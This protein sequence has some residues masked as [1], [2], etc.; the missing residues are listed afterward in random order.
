MTTCKILSPNFLNFPYIYIYNW[1]F[2]IT[3]H[4][5]H[6]WKTL[7]YS[8]PLLYVR[9][10]GKQKSPWEHFKPFHFHQLYHWVF[11]FFLASLSWFDKQSAKPRIPQQPASIIMPKENIVFYSKTLKLLFLP[12]PFFPL[13]VSCECKRS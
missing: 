4:F 1:K 8:H 6:H 5:L 13:M 7:D 11:F 10:W 12:F 9:F 3:L 2:D